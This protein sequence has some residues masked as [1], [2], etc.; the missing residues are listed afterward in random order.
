MLSA[1]LGFFSWLQKRNIIRCFTFEA[2]AYRQ[3]YPLLQWHQSFY[4]APISLP[5]LFYPCSVRWP[6]YVYL[7]GS[8]LASALWS[9]CRFITEPYRR[10]FTSELFTEEEPIITQLCLMSFTAEPNGPSRR[11][12]SPSV[13]LDVRRLLSLY[14]YRLFNFTTHL[15]RAT[16]WSVSGRPPL[17][18]HSLLPR[19]QLLNAAG[20]VN[21]L[22]H[23]SQTKSCV[24]FQP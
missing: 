11:Y 13:A 10:P 3:H 23:F 9:I 22:V 14:P 24:S 17:V 7:Q 19:V 5:A 15:I 21:R 18:R 8:L 6:Q 12:Q 16:Q 20:T 4:G 1:G 2:L